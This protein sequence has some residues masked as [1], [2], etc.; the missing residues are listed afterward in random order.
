MAGTGRGRHKK[1]GGSWAFSPR[2]RHEKCGGCGMRDV[3]SR[4]PVKRA[5]E[6]AKKAAFALRHRTRSHSDPFL[7]LAAIMGA[8]SL[9]TPCVFPMIP[10]TV[11]YFTNHASGNRK[12]AIFTAIHLRDRNRL[13]FTAL[14]MLW[15]RSWCRWREP[16][17]SESVPINLLI[18]AIFLGFAFSLFG[19]YFIQIPPRLM[20]EL[21]PDCSAA[22]EERKRRTRR[23][24]RCSW[25]LR[26]R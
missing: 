10:I 16:V 12:S 21:I 6:S 20:D 4:L 15:R 13:T 2:L 7:W 22:G 19:A 14:G 3:A 11:S 9:L 18:T 24:A 1:S 26:S 5:V 23:S 8:L 17:G 25:D